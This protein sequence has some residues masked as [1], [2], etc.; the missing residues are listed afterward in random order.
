M[1]LQAMSDGVVSL[2]SVPEAGKE[3][4][5]LPV[6]AF[7][8]AADLDLRGL[9][10]A[11]GKEPGSLRVSRKDGNGPPELSP[12]DR[13]GIRKWKAHLLALAVYCQDTTKI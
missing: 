5:D 8:L 6:D 13:D 7:T 3:G 10:I 12:A 1:R 11:P 9:V 4:L 2:R